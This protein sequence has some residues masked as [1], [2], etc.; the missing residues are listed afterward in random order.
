MKNKRK[1]T[2]AGVGFTWQTG[3][4]LGEQALP[5]LLSLVLIPVF[6]VLGTASRFRLKRFRNMSSSRCL[7]AWTLCKISF[8]NSCMRFPCSKIERCASTARPVSAL[9]R[10]NPAASLKRD[11]NIATENL[12]D[13]VFIERT[14][15]EI[16]HAQRFPY[17]YFNMVPWLFW[18]FY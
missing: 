9:K 12:T 7:S 1:L 2:G 8:S 10:E 3:E 17:L 11:Y 14:Q 15:N 16:L 6:E 18:G 5:S 4:F 13:T